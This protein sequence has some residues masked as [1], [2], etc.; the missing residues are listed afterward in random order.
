MKNVVIGTFNTPQH[1]FT[2]QLGDIGK[3]LRLRRK[4]GNL[5]AFSSN[6]EENFSILSGKYL[7]AACLPANF[8]R[9]QQKVAPQAVKKQ[10][11]GNPYPIP[12]IAPAN[13]FKNTDPGMAN[14]CL[15]R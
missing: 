5:E 11:I 10:V 7:V 2:A 15:N 9:E 12:N 4:Y 1:I 14:V 8:A 3:S 6:I 13:K